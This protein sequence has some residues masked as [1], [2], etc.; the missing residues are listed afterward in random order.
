MT[1]GAAIVPPLSISGIEIYSPVAKLRWL[2]DNTSK[3]FQDWL[4]LAVKHAQ[5]PRWAVCRAL[6]TNKLRR[7]QKALRED[8]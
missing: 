5:T 8:D 3:F 4:G 2:K 1:S 6:P 7:P